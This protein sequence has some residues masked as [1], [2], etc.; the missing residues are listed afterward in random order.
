MKDRFMRLLLVIAMLAATSAPA[1]AQGASGSSSI[2]G[3]VV[4]TAG[5]AIPGASV[6]VA[7]DATGTRFEAMT[8]TTGAFAVPALPVGTY[9]VTVSLQGFKTSVV[10]DVRVQLGIP[11]TVK[12]TLEVGGISE[13]ITVTGATAE[14][15]NSQTA[16][17]SSTLNMDQIAQIPMPT[18][19]VLNAV[20]FLVGVNQT[21]DGPGPGDGQRPAGVVPE[22]HARRRQQPGYV[23]QVDRRILRARAAPPGRGRGR[24]GD[25]PPPAAPT[26]AATAPSRSIS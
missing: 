12:A 17:V 5:G 24:D 13:T 21:E 23:Q 6:V 10:T 2:S 8:N 22:H 19:E 26:S 3:V 14:L 9:K 4:D 7:S 15:I 20:T 11:T 18:R 1:F 16:T 25:D